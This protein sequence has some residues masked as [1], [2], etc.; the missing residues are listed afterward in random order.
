MDGINSFIMAQGSKFWG[1]WGSGIKITQ[2]NRDQW[3]PDI[4]CYDPGI[5]YRWMIMKNIL[6]TIYMILS[7]SSWTI[8]S[9]Q[10]SKR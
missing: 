9:E 4:P 6:L 3:V 10:E 1:K 7:N 8:N 2:E 5:K